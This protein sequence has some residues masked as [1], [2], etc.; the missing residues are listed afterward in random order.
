MPELPIVLA[1]GK[2]LRQKAQKVTDFGPDLRSTVQD[3]IDTMR[4]YNGI[5]LAAPQVNIN[6]KIIVAEYIPDRDPKT[7]KFTEPAIPLTVLVNPKITDS[8][9]SIDSLDE[10]CLSIPN[11]ELPVKRPTE[12]NVL[13]EDIDG[14]RVKI[15]AK[16][17]LARILQHEIDHINGILIPERAQPELL[18]ISDLRVVFMGSPAHTIPYLNALAACPFEIVGVVTETDKP[19][20]RGQQVAPT[21]IKEHAEIL[22]LPVFTFETLRD[23]TAKKIFKDL[24]P[25]LVIVA[26]YG[27]IIPKSWL[28]IPTHGFLNIHYSLLP[29][30]RG[31]TPHQ[32][33]ILAGK[34]KSGYTIFK[35]EPG[36]DTG[37]I[38]TQK[39]I[40][41]SPN[42]TSLSLISKM[43]NP[44]V[45]SL[46][47]TL[48]AYVKGKKKLTAQNDNK[49]T[50]TREF[51]KEDGRIDWSR[52]ISEIDCQI[53]GLMPWPNAFTELNGERLI[54]LASHIENDKLVIDA[55]KPSGKKA[56]SFADWQRGNPV[57][58]LTFLA[59]TGKVK[60]VQT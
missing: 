23:K 34:K 4:K 16:D 20:G 38:L 12:V 24:K 18:D 47:Q 5:G 15:R 22:G 31:A 7:G 40:D 21:A 25:D 44:S 10:G 52:P 60:L 19:T 50:S 48:P 17:L 45:V 46:L 56:M 39:E 53:R 2:I 6:K 58:W 55:V 3:M 36:L 27:K 59:K 43:I 30:F 49:A 1:P 29:E 42:D 9:R 33:A 57:N 11:I 13:A 41:I 14:N 37:P 51:T 26:A 28:E 35:L 8:N 54:I 32:S